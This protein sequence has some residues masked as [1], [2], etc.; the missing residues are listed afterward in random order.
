M[1]SARLVDAEVIEALSPRG[2]LINIARGSVVDQDAL[3]DALLSGRLAGAGLD[4]GRIRRC[5]IS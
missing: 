4:G 1:A 5:P 3:V 2:Y